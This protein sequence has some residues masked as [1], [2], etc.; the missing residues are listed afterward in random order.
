MTYEER[1]ERLRRT[2]EAQTSQK[3]RDNKDYMNE[4]DYGSVPAPKDVTIEIE[5][6]DPVHRTFYGAKAWAGNFRRLLEKHPIYIDPDDALA[7]RWMYI[8]QRLRPFESAVSKNNMEMAPIFDYDFLKPTQEKYGIIPGIGK[9]HH[10]APDYAIG[11]ALGWGGLQKKL[12]ECR[13]QHPESAWL[14]DAEDEVMAGIR[15]WTRRTVERLKEMETE[16]RDPERKENLRQMRT[17]NEN[18]LDRAPQTFHEACQ[19]IAWFNMLN[20]SYNRAGSGCQ[21]DELLR[22]YYERDLAQGRIDREKPSLSC[23]VFCSTIPPTIR[24]AVLRPTATT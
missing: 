3:L 20:R 2:K 7:G 14:Y 9:M 8:L 10:F 6:N 17:V 13:N 16:E 18:I 21:I 12:N 11:L 4:D 5:Y 23:A 19:W 24:W 15:N 22:P 1:I